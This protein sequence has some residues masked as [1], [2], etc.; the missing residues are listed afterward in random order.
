[1][2]AQT[3]RKL[4][5]PRGLT[6]LLRQHFDDFF[7]IL[8]KSCIFVGKIQKKTI[9]IHYDR[10]LAKITNKKMI[11]RILNLMLM[12]IL[13]ASVANAKVVDKE[14]AARVAAEFLSVSQTK[15]RAKAVKV[16]EV[17]PRVHGRRLA[18]AGEE[19][20]FY[21]FTPEDGC[22]FVIV[23]ADDAAI[24]V[25]GYSATG[26]I[27]EGNI[28]PALADMMEAWTKQICEARSRGIEPDEQTKRRWAMRKAPV[29]VVYLETAKWNQTAPYNGQCPKINGEV[30]YTGCVP[31]AHSILMR[32]YRYAKRVS[33]ITEEYTCGS[34]VTVPSRTIT[35]DYDWNNMPLT[36]P[37]GGY[38]DKRDDAVA[39]LMADIGA[40]C[41]A[42]YKESGTG[43]TTSQPEMLELF[44]YHSSKRLYR[45][46]YSDSEWNSMI[47]DDLDKH[48]PVLYDGNGYDGYTTTGHAFLLDGYDSDNFYHVNWGWGGHYNGYFS[49]NSM[50]PREGENYNG[51]QGAVFGIYPID[52][53]DNKEPEYVAQVGTAYFSMLNYAFEYANY[54]G[55]TVK[56]LCDVSMDQLTLVEGNV[57]LDINGH[58]F[59][60]A[61]YNFAHLTIQDSQKSGKIAIKAAKSD[62]IVNDKEGTLTL[63][64]V[65]I[66]GGT[67]EDF[68]MISNYGTAVIRGCKLSGS[69][70]S[71]F[72]YNVKNMDIYDSEITGEGSDTWLAYG[73]DESVLNI[74]GGKYL[75]K[76]GFYT[77]KGSHVNVYGGIF[78]FP[79]AGYTAEG[80]VAEDNPNKSTCE[81]YPYTV[82]K[83]SEVPE[84]TIIA[85]VNGVQFN[86]LTSALDYAVSLTEV[87]NIQM[88]EDVII[89]NINLAK[90]NI[91]LD[92]NGHALST[93]N[94]LNST[95]LTIQDSKKSGKIEIMPSSN[96]PVRN[97]QEGT[98]TLEDVTIEG[99]TKD[100][101]CLIRNEGTAE[102][103][104]CKLTGSPASTMI[105][106]IKNMD[107][108]DSE[109]TGEG[110]DTWLAYGNDES[111][112]NIH[113]GRFSTKYD[114]RS[115]YKF[116]ELSQI[117]VYEGLFSFSP[118]KQYIA[119]GSIVA[120][121][122]DTET[123]EKYPYWVYS[124][125][126]I[127]PIATE[128]NASR[129]LMHYSLDGKRVSNPR[130]GSVVI[131]R[132]SD[133][134]V[135]KKIMK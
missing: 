85:S 94:I 3:L 111:V 9:T 45:S 107:I 130:P 86:S 46:D 25:L 17:A 121:N 8:Q 75:A 36:Y 76:K 1:M 4:H 66:E 50:Q 119:K 84:G 19:P 54:A 120:S 81:Q 99:G 122:T 59:T 87:A 125:T 126:G 48:H 100:N 55:E 70:A 26:T 106:N 58:T 108:Y 128:G 39:Q 116:N 61:I 31:T 112:L 5:Q 127:S 29:P 90:G 123:S 72:I 104:G 24:P 65:T 77:G 10:E 63:E 32:Y 71:T 40:L 12:L 79:M 91:V 105:Y 34:G 89:S 69:P 53:Y 22:G 115:F 7:A 102:I 68:S 96:Y 13:T 15:Q 110:S 37:Y 124:P 44:G 97:S 33:V 64:N 92:I 35:G 41:K 43:A 47:L 83:I 129:P 117:N 114:W 6:P 56:L 11:R 16:R 88:L 27:D 51:D 80:Y 135:V 30:R 20:A 21:I 109:I 131:T 23:S 14:E 73:N 49:L 134:S 132:N 57:I 118:D 101:Y 82:R 60:T 95:Q 52:E 28:P 2:R 93:T 103:R 78:S 42:N 38:G 98:L 113:S 74:H 18:P 133:G 67:E 62:P